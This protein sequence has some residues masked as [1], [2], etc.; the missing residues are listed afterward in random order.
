MPRGAHAAENPTKFV[1]FFLAAKR[2]RTVKARGIGVSLVLAVFWSIGPCQ[3]VPA[4]D[5]GRITGTVMLTL[6]DATVV[7][8]DWIRVLLV[9]RAVE[10]PEA[11]DMARL[12]KFQRRER[13][14]VAHM[15]FFKRVQAE[16][17]DSITDKCIGCSVCKKVCPTEA[18][19]GERS[20]LH[21]VVAERCIDCAA[22]GR[23]CPQAAVLD[24]NRN[25]C[26]RRPFK[27]RWEKPRIDRQRCVSCWICVDACPVDCLGWVFTR[28]TTDKKGYPRLDDPRACIA[29]GFCAADCPVDAVTL[30]IPAA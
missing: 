8:G 11:A 30:A 20:K 16:M 15:D 7:Y 23:V 6:D 24:P 5:T 13:I 19:V 26:E 21:K 3:A 18:I 9:R 4:A 29:C 10:L 22:C 17:A 12:D 27:A 28:D 1:G 25:V 14:N 2:S